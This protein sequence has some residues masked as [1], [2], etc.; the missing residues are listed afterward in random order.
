MNFEQTQQVLHWQNVLE[1]SAELLIFKKDNVMTGD[2]LP[3]YLLVIYVCCCFFFVLSILQS[4]EEVV[5]YLLACHTLLL[6][7]FLLS[8]M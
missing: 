2:K 1:N 6:E 8:L 4:Q 5:I 7:E 3:K